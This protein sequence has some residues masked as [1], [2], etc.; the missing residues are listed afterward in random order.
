MSEHLHVICQ[1]VNECFGVTLQLQQPF[2]HG[3]EDERYDISILCHTKVKA[4]AR[5]S[6]YGTSFG[7]RERVNVRNNKVD[8][9]SCSSNVFHNSL[10]HADCFP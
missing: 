6:T 3:V 9:I 7:W 5:Y 8:K 2:A 10:A 4:R 1:Q